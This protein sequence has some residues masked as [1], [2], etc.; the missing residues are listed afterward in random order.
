[1][2]LLILLIVSSAVGALGLEN[3][4][5]GAHGWAVVDLVIALVLIEELVDQARKAV[6]KK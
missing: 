1:M 2:K 6:K 4:R 5:A 3:Y